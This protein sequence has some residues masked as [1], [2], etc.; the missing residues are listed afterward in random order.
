MTR[1]QIKSGQKVQQTAHPEYGAWVIQEHY[2]S[3]TWN[4]KGN[5]GVI[6]VDEAELI[7]FWEKV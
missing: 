1:E 6:C 3:S 4:V 2:A 7:K 5:N